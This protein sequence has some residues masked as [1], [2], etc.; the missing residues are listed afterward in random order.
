MSYYD[1]LTKSMTMLAEHPQTLFVGQS[2]KFGGQA[3]T[4]SFSG[5][6]E[7]R[8]MEFPVCENMQM[9]FCIGLSLEGFIPVCVFPRMDFMLLALDQLVNHADKIAQISG[10][11]PK[12][13]IRTAVGSTSPL[14]PGP[15][16]MQNYTAAFRQMLTTIPVIELLG[17]DSIVPIY[18]KALEM[19]GPVVI[20][21]HAGKYH[22]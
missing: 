3:M 19:D 12:V 20:V 6:S 16:H 11:R 7:D 2:V 13:I 5:V 1:E 17:S 14:H 10:Y 4:K 21:E 18:Q 22:E 9:G 8:K 15:Q